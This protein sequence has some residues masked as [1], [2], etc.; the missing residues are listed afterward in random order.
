MNINLI[1]DSIIDNV[2]NN[3]R[4]VKAGAT[5][6][7]NLIGDIYL[8][9]YDST[10]NTFDE[11]HL[12]PRQI[13][14]TIEANKQYP[15]I[16]LINGISKAIN[17]ELERKILGDYRNT[18]LMDNS[19]EGLI[20]GQWGRIVINSIEDIEDEKIKIKISSNFGA[21][22]MPKTNLMMNHIIS[23]IKKLN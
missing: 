2:K 22:Y 4:L 16:P 8:P 15:D 6:L 14:L 18:D 9:V 20:I 11:I 17:D 1:L 7:T 13:N 5:F 10:N 3:S 12:L 19:L 21:A 23:N